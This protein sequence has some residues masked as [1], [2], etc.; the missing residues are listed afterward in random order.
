MAGEGRTGWWCINT[1]VNLTINLEHE[2]SRRGSMGLSLIR[3]AC[4]ALV[5]VNLSSFVRD[6]LAPTA[7]APFPSRGAGAS[8]T[9]AKEGQTGLF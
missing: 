3:I 4:A 6:S 2:S 5:L 7:A 1:Y 9:P 8:E